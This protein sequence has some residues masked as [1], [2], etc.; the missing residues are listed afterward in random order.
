MPVV[1]TQLLPTHGTV[2][3]PGHGG[4]LRSKS[5][6]KKYKMGESQRGASEIYARNDDTDETDKGKPPVKRMPFKETSLPRP[7]NTAS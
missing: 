3:N 5:K 1:H 2:T 4:R 6:H 7:R